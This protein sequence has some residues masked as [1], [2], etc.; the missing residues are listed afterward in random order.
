MT[1]RFHTLLIL[2]LNASPRT[3]VSFPA[4]RSVLR[5]LRNYQHGACAMLPN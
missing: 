5:P 3:C 2:L 1:H 4:T